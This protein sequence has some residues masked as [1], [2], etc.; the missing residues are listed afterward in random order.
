MTKREALKVVRKLGL[1][2][3]KGKE[4]FFKLVHDGTTILTTAVPKGRG[5]LRIERKF[6]QQLKLTSEQLKGAIK[7]PFKRKDFLAHLRAISVIE[8]PEPRQ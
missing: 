3:R 7:C 1:K 5:D 2:E 4:L 8:Q 6:R